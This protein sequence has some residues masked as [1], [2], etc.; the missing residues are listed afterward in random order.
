M[1]TDQKNKFY[2]KL[3]TNIDFLISSQI[4]YPK[5]INTGVMKSGHSQIDIV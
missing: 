4:V 1:K 5:I 3:E 2:E